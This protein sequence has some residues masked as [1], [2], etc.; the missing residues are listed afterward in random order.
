M[1]GFKFIPDVKFEN[2]Y[3]NAK[4]D[5]IKALEAI[6]RLTKDQQRQLLGELL[7]TEFAALIYQIIQSRS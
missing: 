4:K 6:N 1:D 7:G 2:P 3:E 5:V